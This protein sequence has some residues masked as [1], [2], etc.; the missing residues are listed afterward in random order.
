ME[1][2]YVFTPHIWETS[3]NSA[4]LSDW[5]DYGEAIGFEV[6]DE[7]PWDGD[8]ARVYRIF[9]QNHQ[10]ALLLLEDEFNIAVSI[11]TMIAH[12]F[13]LKDFKF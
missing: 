13:T 9:R 11:S 6:E 12:G 1:V 10:D 3:G 8:I 2:F 4:L 7:I 5:Q